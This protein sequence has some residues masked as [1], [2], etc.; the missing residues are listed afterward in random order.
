MKCKVC[1]SPNLEDYKLARAK[2]YNFHG[3]AVRASRTNG[4]KISGIQFKK[5]FEEGHGIEEFG[6]EV[7]T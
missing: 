1:S 4:E 3:L 5:H 7:I 2:G 6:R